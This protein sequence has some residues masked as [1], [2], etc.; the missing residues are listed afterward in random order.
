[1]GPRADEGVLEKGKVPCSG[2]D[3]PSMTRGL[4]NPQSD[5]ALCPGSA[6][7]GTH[8]KRGTRNDFQ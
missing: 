3:L 2:Q 1:M 6:T 5:D 4:V 8:A 7:Y